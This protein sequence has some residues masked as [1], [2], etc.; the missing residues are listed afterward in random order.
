[1]SKAFTKETDQDDD[2]HRSAE[3]GPGTRRGRHGADGSRGAPRK[4]FPF[5]IPGA[6]DSI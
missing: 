2:G 3:T 1:M 4:K 5:A 6:A